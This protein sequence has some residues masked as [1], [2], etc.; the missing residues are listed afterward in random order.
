MTRHAPQP[1]GI[2]EPKRRHRANFDDGEQPPETRV[3]LGH[4]RQDHRHDVNDDDANDQPD[5]ARA[6]RIRQVIVLKQF[7]EPIPQIRVAQSSPAWGGR[8]RQA[9]PIAFSIAVNA[10][11]AL[12]PSGPAACAM[13]GRPPPPLPPSAS[14]ATRTRLTALNRE[15][16]S[17]VTPTTTPALPSSVTP[18][19][20]TT[21]EPICFLPSSARLLRSFISMPST[22]RAISLTSPTSRTPVAA[23]LP[24]PAPPPIA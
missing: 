15:T 2:F 24:S 16:R 18:M 21:P 17:A 23:P 7:V 11:A 12:A 6:D 13:S 19:M 20:A 1:R 14:E 9:L 10:A 5:E 3:E 4:R 22:A 8:H